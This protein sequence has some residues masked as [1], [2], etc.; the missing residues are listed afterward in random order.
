MVKKNKKAENSLFGFENVSFQRLIALVVTFVALV[1]MV[2]YEAAPKKYKLS[3]GDISQYDINA[4]RDI[5]NTLKTREN[6]E[7]KAAE[8]KPVIV[9]IEGQTTA[10]QAVPT[11]ILTGL[12]P[13][14]PGEEQPAGE[15]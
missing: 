10:L 11:H 14:R 7:Q 1:A 3:V 15:G 8:L 2:A 6:A 12:R 9:P 13:L 5:E 4:P